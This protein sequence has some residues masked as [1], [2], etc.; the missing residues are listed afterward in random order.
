MQINIVARALKAEGRP[1]G[2]L[3]GALTALRMAYGSE[4]SRFCNG[5]RPINELIHDFEE[6]GMEKI[7]NHLRIGWHDFKARFHAWFLT[8]DEENILKSELKELQ[9]EIKSMI[10][11]RVMNSRELPLK[12]RIAYLDSVLKTYHAVRKDSAFTGDES[13]AQSVFRDLEKG[14]FLIDSL[15]VSINGDFSSRVQKGI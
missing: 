8:P 3:L 5:Q 4:I 11:S 14:M 2:F 15:N 10:E 1:F 6:D 7:G 13:P 9:N 12:N